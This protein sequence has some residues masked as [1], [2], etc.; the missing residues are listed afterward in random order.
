MSNR[1]APQ[2]S[3]QLALASAFSV[4]AMVAFVVLGVDVQG[5]DAGVSLPAVGVSAEMPALP[6]PVDLLPIRR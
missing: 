4:M 3:T 2:I 6:A 5:V 1:P